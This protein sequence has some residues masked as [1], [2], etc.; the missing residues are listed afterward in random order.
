MIR[1]GVLTFHRSVNEGSV[2]QAVCTVACLQRALDQLGLAHEVCIVDYRP[3]RRERREYWK[4]LR[5]LLR[6]RSAQAQKA[7][8]LRRWLKRQAALGG[9]PCWA[10]DPARVSTWLQRG[11]WDLL[12]TGSDTVWAVSPENGLPDPPNP[13]FLPFDLP[14]RR[15]SLAASADRHDSRLYQGDAGERIAAALAAFDWISV[16]DAGTSAL[17]E[18]LQIEHELIAD[19]TILHGVQNL[20]S[21]AHAAPSVSPDGRPVLGLALADEGQRDA[22]ARRFQ[23]RGWQVMNMLGRS[24]VPGVDNRYPGRPMDDKLALL[25]SGLDGVVT[26]RFHVTIFVLSLGRCPLAV[27]RRPGNTEGVTGKAEDLLQRLDCTQ[28]LVD[29]NRGDWLEAIETVLAREPDASVAEALERL[30]SAGQSQLRTALAR[31]LAEVPAA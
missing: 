22:V 26:D 21:S 1:V 8:H 16:R 10:E 15:L 20:V 13:Y 31:V 2:A 29:F 6:G 30:A 25:R 7:W 12:V 17:L 28:F 11:N 19:P 4:I 3:W 27:L 24:G 14:V 5:P 18:R 9:W 23:A